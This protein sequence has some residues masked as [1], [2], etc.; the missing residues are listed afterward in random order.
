MAPAAP[1]GPYADLGSLPGPV[2]SWPDHRIPPLCTGFLVERHLPNI[3]HQ[4]LG[5]CLSPRRVGAV[6]RIAAAS[7]GDPGKAAHCSVRSARQ[8]RNGEG[9][10]RR[11][12]LG[13]KWAGW[14]CTDGRR[15]PPSSASLAQSHPDQA[16]GQVRATP[17][18]G[19]EE[20]ATSTR[21]HGSVPQP[22]RRGSHP[23]HSPQGDVG[24]HPCQ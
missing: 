10:K 18:L 7:R 14:K 11:S 16:S 3:L 5:L 19:R 12:L 22:C 15:H 2:P 1:C 17:R 4:R 13:R 9:A 23:L 20:R 24:P 6:V 21:L 8:S